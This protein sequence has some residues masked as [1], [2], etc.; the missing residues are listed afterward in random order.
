MKFTKA[1]VEY[2]NEFLNET[3]EKVF[4]IMM[5]ERKM[6]PRKDAIAFLFSRFVRHMN[7]LGLVADGERVK[8]MRI[9]AICHCSKVHENNG[10]MKFVFFTKKKTR[11]SERETRSKKGEADQTQ[12]FYCTDE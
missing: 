5:H 8:D 11:H 7:A 9:I 1:P 6:F 12:T 2:T 4:Q 10:A 3:H